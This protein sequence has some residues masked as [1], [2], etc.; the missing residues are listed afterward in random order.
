MKTILRLGILL[1]VLTSCKSDDTS[2]DDLPEC[3]QPIVTTILELPVQTPKATIDLYRYRGEEVYFV[4]A[5]HW[6]DGQAALISL[7]CEGICVFGGIDGPQNDCED[8]D[9]LEFVENVWT[10]P[11]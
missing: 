7:N 5:Q 10:D 9:T 3:L 4:D 8:Q 1:L 6:P 2:I 11:R